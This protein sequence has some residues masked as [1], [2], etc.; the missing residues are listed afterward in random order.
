MFRKH[1]M[2]VAAL[3]ISFFIL[4][5][6]GVVPV[7]HGAVDGVGKANFEAP[8]ETAGSAEE[9]FAKLTEGLTADLNDPQADAQV[10][11]QRLG[12]RRG[13]LD[14]LD[15]DIRKQFADTEK[16][17]KD[18]K[19][20]AEILE[21]HRAFVKHYEENLAEL[22]GNMARV[23]KAK[24]AAGVAVE[25]EKTRQHLE[26]VKAP[27]RPKAPGSKRLSSGAEKP[28]TPEPRLKK[29]EFEGE[30]KKDKNAWNHE[31]PVMVATVGSLAGLLSSAP[32]AAVNL[33]TPD[34][35]SETIDIQ[36]TPEIK[37]KSLELGSDP[38][39]IYEWV[40]N[41]IEYVPTYGSIQ[42]ADQCLRTKQCNDIDTASLLIALLRSSGIQAR[43][44]YGTIEVPIDRAMSWVGGMSDPLAT[45]DL[46][47]SG[48][49]PVKTIISGG[50]I[51]KLQLEH[52][53]VEA[54]ID[55]IPSRGARHSGGQG[56]TWIPLDASFKLHNSTV[57]LDLA[58]AA[59]FDAQTFVNQLTG[60]ATISEAESYATNV[61]C[62]AVSQY[63]QG[64]RSGLQNFLA[65][66]HPGATVG[67][68][69]GSTSL[70]EQ[71]FPYLIGTLPYQ[72]IVKGGV[73]GELPSSLR[74]SVTFQLVNND[75]QSANYSETSFSLTLGLPKLAGKR[76]SLS[77]S[78]ATAADEAVIAAYA[79]RP[80]ADG[81]AISLSEYPAS[82]PAYL[83][84]VKG[85]LRVDG[86]VVA[87]GIGAQLGGFEQFSIQA[88]S[89]HLPGGGQEFF[90]KAGEYVGIAFGTG[91][92][93]P[94][95]L[96]A[97]KTA[98]EETTARLKSGGG[99][100]TKD[101]ILGSFLHA[102]ALAN[103]AESDALNSVRARGMGI[104]FVRRPSSSAVT[105]MLSTTY[106]FGI[107]RYINIAGPS[108]AE[109]GYRMAISAR[110]GNRD[111]ARRYL[112]LTGLDASA[113]AASLQEYL[114]SAP[115]YPVTSVSAAKAMKTASERA[116]PVYRLTP[117]NSGTVIGKLG[118]A[119]E[120]EQN[121]TNESGEGLTLVVPQRNVTV[122][123]W[124]G[125]GYEAHSFTSGSNYT[126]LNGPPTV[127]QGMP[128]L[129]R[130]ILL[131]LL[132]SNMV[133]PAT[134]SSAIVTDSF[135]TNIGGVASGLAGLSTG[136]AIES[137]DLLTSSLLYDRLGDKLGCYLDLGSP[138]VSSGTCMATYLSLICTAT[139]TPIIAD[140]NSRP[141][142]DAGADRV[143]G[144]GEVVT[145]DGS[146]SS[147]ADKEPLVYQWRFA[148][149][150][151][152]SSATLTGATTAIPSFTVD[153]AGIYRVELMVSD[154]KKS[155]LPATVTVIAYPAT[156]I[157]P[158]LVGLPTEEAK[159]AIRSSGLSVGAISAAPDGTVVAGRVTSQSPAAGSSADRGSSVQFVVS[160]GPQAD[161]EPPVVS[162]SLDRTPPLYA[163]G[164]PVRITVGATD[165]VGIS[166]VA[167]TV[168]GTTVPLGQPVTII[169]T[170]GYLPGSSHTVQ[171]I[172]RDIS[173]NSA[174][175]TATFGILDPADTTAPKIAI[176]SPAADA[177][178]TAPVDIIGSVVDSNLF[179]YTL[180]YTPTG[181]AAYTVFA[182]G[183][184]AT[185]GGVLGRLDPTLMQNGIY[186]IVLTAVDANGNTTSYALQYR[187]TGDLKV[188]NFTVSFTDLNVPVAGIP[189]TVTRSYDSRNKQNGDFG[190]G[191]NIDIQS[192]KIEENQSPGEG[193]NLTS[194][195]GDW[196]T[197]CVGSEG[198]RYITITLPDGRVEEF[199][200]TVTPKCQALVPIQYPTIGYTPRAGTTS[201]LKAKNVGQ[202]Y[203][204]PSGVLFDLD[205][206]GPYNPSQYLLTTA[207]GAVY[208][209]DQTFGVRKVTDPNGNSLTYGTSGVIHSSGKSLSFSRDAKG[210]ITQVTDPAGKAIG[211]SYDANGNLATVTDQGG[212]VTRYTYNSTHGLIDIIDPLGRRAVRNE[213]DNS[214]R[215]IAHI[216]AD[217]K[218][219]EYNHDIAGRQEVVKDRNGNL[220]VYIYDEQGR[221]LQKTDPLGKTVSYTYDAVG[222]KL[223]ETDPLGNKTSWTYD[224]RKNVLSETKTIDGTAITTSHTYNG[225]GK[226]L[227]T[228]DPKGNVT[229]NT[230]DAKGNL[231]TSKDPLGSVTTNTYDANGNLLTTTDALGNV[232][233][234]EYDASGNQT[235]QTTPSGAVT[236]YTYDIKGNKLSETDARGGTTLYGYDST[237][238]LLKITDALGNVTS[239]EYD[240]AGNKTAETNPLGFVTTYLYDT[241]NRVVETR[242]PDGTS[243]KTGY[244]AEGNRATSTD[245]AGRVTSYSYNANK[246]L[247][248]TTYSDGT[249]TETGYDAAGRQTTTT[250]AAGKVS[251]REYDAL[252][253]V[254]RTIDPE[255]HGVSF[256]Y[257]ANGN[258]TRQTDANGHSTSYEYDANNRQVKITLP[259]GQSTSTSYD[260]LGRK[261]FETD[262]AGN[263][264]TFAYDAN[265]NLLSVTDADG[266]V[267]GYEYDKNNN[268]I[269]IVDAN[270][271]R[272]EFTFDRLNRLLTKTMPNGGAELYEYDAA[273]RQV[274]K[275]DAKGQKIAYG[276]D[277]AN[278]LVTRTYPDESSVSFTYTQTGK[279]ATATDRRGATTYTYDNRDRL[280][281]TTT[282]DGQSI[283][284]GYDPT[285]RIS[286]ISGPGG[287]ITHAY[288]AGGRLASVSDPQGRTTSYGYDA[289]GNRTG[290]TYP[291]G[292]SISYGYDVNNRLTS[293]GH[294]AVGQVASYA[295]TLGPIGNRTRIDEG[296]GISRVYTYDKLYR[297]TREQ[298]S[299]PTSAQTYS[300][301]FTYDAVGNRQNRS[302]AAEAKPV[303]STDY[304]YNAADQL[305]SESGV[306]YT[307]DLNGSLASKTDGSGTTAYVYDFDNRLVKVT[308][309]TQ[310][311]TYAY[312][313]DGNRI[314]S[315]GP[316]GT[317]RFLVDTNRSLSQVL[318]E[319]RPDNTIIASY[320]YADDLISM[321]RGD[322]TYWYHFDG[323]G[324][325]RALTDGTGAVTDTYDYDAFGN[326]IARTGTTE[327]P[328][329][330]TGQR[331]DANTGFYHLRARYYQPGVGRFTAV[332]PWEGDVYAPG[333]LHR[334][335]YTANDPVNKVDPS[336]CSPLTVFLRLAARILPASLA[337]ALSFGRF[338]HEEI[339]NDIIVGTKQ[340]PFAKREQPVVGG[341]VDILDVPP[342]EIYEIK[343]LGGSKSGQKQL[344]EYLNNNP[345]L[346]QG[347]NYLSGYINNPGG[348]AGIYIEYFTEDP[349]VVLY[350]AGVK[351]QLF[352]PIISMMSALTATMINMQIQTRTMLP[353]LAW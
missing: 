251:T 185:T 111:K 161:A 20:P 38:L 37:A 86:V 278:R 96:L 258:Q 2:I 35:L 145:L 115:G 312:D 129:G 163:A 237:G 303:V 58:S 225:L 69:L 159:N 238:K 23:E 177:A 30:S 256:A 226:V 264:T 247:V 208:E 261:A 302:L 95:H 78:P 85:E 28:N 139:S 60:S 179:E 233:S 351:P 4:T 206:L 336:G 300:N 172:A 46:L 16:K 348:L 210:R 234:H 91:P 76:V 270:G 120:V 231:L 155:S 56:D 286:T 167:I 160:T 282:P 218:R 252:G 5:S 186:D 344:N 279:R 64:F 216:D 114:L 171:V 324:S 88:F 228:T 80:H 301:D 128:G 153:V 122:G 150:P 149:L 232:T 19:L 170:T 3:V 245:R 265:G 213:Y 319:Y 14:A 143:V 17:L 134:L 320:T 36:F 41:T 283:G 322:Q 215:I 200:M 220:T 209:L 103:L 328:F 61:Q 144:V 53:W 162:V 317:I 276:Y 118:L 352:L 117:A 299:D 199:D 92:V 183:N 277:A 148:A 304:S 194:T 339:E 32:S 332:D 192:I 136:P 6:G 174:T 271:H 165:T 72:T 212:N 263:I 201:M 116:I 305:V 147:D 62:A 242:Y 98:L 353:S 230:Y 266:K 203:V 157:A 249:T 81:T 318:A 267:T 236:S 84:Q 195:G 253:R 106:F 119:E 309:P 257:D 102:S 187:I 169:D 285:G 105:L 97:A 43:Y 255:N 335:L 204:S 244:D 10:K 223:S 331:F 198:E 108:N 130:S 11:R 281:A 176:T 68:V 297:L 190:Y 79:P 29:E 241:A 217:G 314:E 254:T 338:A 316:E 173:L 315:A 126:N 288:S 9:R 168:D 44:A 341:R 326:L 205:N 164:T 219:I 193:W 229:S 51:S 325:T 191:W 131:S 275:T 132:P 184:Q 77:Y 113:S 333:T 121:I 52:A 313:V 295:Y 154:G 158:S 47:S 334:Y 137:L 289:A 1:A 340:L 75:T 260:V 42:G 63:Q 21:R 65:T 248:K 293:L 110:D 107:P 308:T 202:V 146:R 133:P 330:F 280:T 138:A 89:P 59:P 189:V 66:E 342:K 207:D 239:Y 349:G 243:T 211:Y 99:G 269:A 27:A 188:G 90:I 124:T 12:A 125:V 214:G 73:Y 34:D 93:S 222:N 140:K 18:A 182:R 246:Q 175:T 240:K 142:A 298:V 74:H 39:R 71:S 290:L 345:G 123:A 49:V 100:L 327:N 94:E 25:I 48:G 156:V 15:A 337:T 259:G 197:Y 347:S 343:P 101:E 181:K 151:D 296:T 274:A 87:T 127:V 268:R 135:V 329:L 112:L 321:T 33:P 306:T 83:I 55:Y 82:L 8:A 22:K 45:A 31:K 310:T 227:T 287:T 291:N 50:V 141:V 323:L 26:K 40:R 272:T 7:V 109:M 350:A 311:L 307:Y 294:S 67:D 284:Y 178:I 70:V 180:A 250:D 166:D 346:S 24:D 54:W 262:A 57:A 224:S 273:G 292:A 152:G 196:P 13:E 104:A 235:K 221:V